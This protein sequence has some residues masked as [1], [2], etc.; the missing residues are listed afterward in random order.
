M[1]IIIISTSVFTAYLPS[2]RK[3]FFLLSE[4][5]K[6][7]VKTTKDGISTRDYLHGETERDRVRGMQ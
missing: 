3:H 6:L 4:P 2:L 5:I 1:V 7:E